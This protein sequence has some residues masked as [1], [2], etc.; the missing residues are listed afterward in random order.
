MARGWLG[1]AFVFAGR[2]KDGVQYLESAIELAPRDPR[3]RFFMTH[4]A[5]AFLTLGELEN[6]LNWARLAAQSKSDF[7]EAPA[8]LTSILAH[9]GKYEEAES[10]LS[11]HN[12]I[13]ISSISER[14]FWRR[15]LYPA[16]KN[17]IVEG[18]RKLNFKR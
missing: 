13:N 6:A 15:Y 2:D 9:L 10:V 4:L 14:P 3:N 18:L 1:A 8:A 12:I 17:L 16:T 7:V 11:Q 5:L